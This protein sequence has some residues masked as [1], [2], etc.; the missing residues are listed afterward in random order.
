MVDFDV[1]A[2][3][4]VFDV[5]AGVVGLEVGMRVVGWMLLGVAS[6]RPEV[7]ANCRWVRQW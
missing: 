3:V 4:V 5:G 2:A 7:A 1:G 6:Y